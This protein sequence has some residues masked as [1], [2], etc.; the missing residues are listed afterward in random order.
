MVADDINTV[1]DVAAERR[2]DARETITPASEAITLENLFDTIDSQAVTEINV[3]LKADNMGSVDVVRQTVEDVSHPEVRFKVL[4]TAVGG[5][6]EDDVLLASA[7][8]AFII[9]FGVVPDIRARAAVQRTGVDVK[10]YDVIYEITEDLEKALEGELGYESHE[11]V[12]GH[13]TIRATFKA[14]KYGTIAGCYVTDGI[15]SRDCNVRLV[16]DGKVIHT[17]KLDS[18]KR[19]KDDVK[20]VRENYECGLHLSN[21]N[22]IKEEDVLEAFTVVEVKRTLESSS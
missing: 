3:L 14:S 8:D 6:T 12:I 13:A 20:E 10:F 4:R 17:G 16:R 21:Y 9:G 7:S 11:E 2:E 22:D 18:L 1:R 19:F 15:L 5:I